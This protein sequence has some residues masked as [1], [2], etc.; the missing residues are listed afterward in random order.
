MSI[1][2]KDRQEIFAMIKA[3]VEVEVEALAAKPDA[4]GLI[5]VRHVGLPIDGLAPQQ[6]ERA[7]SSYDNCCNGCD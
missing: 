6:T 2:E 3:E 5:D 4:P 7:A 1:T